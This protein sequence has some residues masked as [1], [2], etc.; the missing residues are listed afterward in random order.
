MRAY[1]QVLDRIE[2]DLA[3]GLV[4]VGGRLPPERALAERYQ[5]SRASVREAIKVLEAMGLIRTGVGSGPDAGA[6]VIADVSAPIGSALRWHLASRHLPVG[7][8]VATRVLL[9]TWAVREAAAGASDESSLR[10]AG[11]L[12]DRMN[13]ADPA[14]QE[15]FLDL[16]TRFHLALAEA[17]GNTVVIAIMQAMRS[18]VRAYVTRAVADFAGWPR[19][20]ERLAAEHRQILEAIQTSDGDAAARSVAAHINGFHQET[21]VGQ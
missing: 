12:L 20:R 18:G 7:D 21:G 9:E 4:D 14:D 19:L 16:D 1:E 15:G 5:V 17:T 8:L 2:Q 10:V 13:G 3:A 11:E 6:V